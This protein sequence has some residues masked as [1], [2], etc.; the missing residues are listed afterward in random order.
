MNPL[1]MI[2]AVVRSDAHKSGVVSTTVA[3]PG[4]I[5]AYIAIRVA[6]AH[7]VPLSM[8]DVFAIYM[9]GPAISSYVLETMRKAYKSALIVYTDIMT[10]FQRGTSEPRSEK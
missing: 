4:S 3:V 8:E 9:A 10:A 2:R 7:K 5:A 1:A 6:D